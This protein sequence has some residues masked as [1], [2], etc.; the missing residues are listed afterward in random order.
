M[1]KNQREPRL[2]WLLLLLLL[3]GE[4]FTSGCGKSY[5]EIVFTHLLLPTG[6]LQTAGADIRSVAVRECLDK[7]VTRGMVLVIQIK[8]FIYLCGRDEDAFDV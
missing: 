2:F 3:Q 1:W 8:V 6:E 4:D 7:L 5:E